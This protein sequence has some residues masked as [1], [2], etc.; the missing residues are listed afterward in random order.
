MRQAASAA[1]ERL[2]RRA[3]PAL[4]AACEQKDPEVRSRASAV[5]SRVEGALLTHPTEVR[6]DFQDAPISEV[7]RSLSEQTG[8]KFTLQPEN[9]PVLLGRKVTIHEAAP[10]T[11]WKAID[12]VCDAGRLQYNF[13]MNTFPRG[14]EPTFPLFDGAIRPSSPVSDSGPFRV[15]L[16][17]VHYQRDVSFPA[18]PVFGR[19]V[20]NPHQ[21]NRPPPAVVNEQFYA[22]MQIAG[23][24]RLSLVQSCAVESDRSG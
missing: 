10:L 18:G 15:T 7:V 8:V 9:S 13:G 16:V 14:S 19:N 11:F 22:Q 3:L 1:L 12:R 17:T 4:K 24:P 20:R 23:E 5:L 6:L 21:L 2:G